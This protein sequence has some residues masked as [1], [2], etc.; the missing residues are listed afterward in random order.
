MRDA[1]GATYAILLGLDFPDERATT[2]E[3]TRHN[4]SLWTL[5]D[6]IAV[7]ECQLHRPVKWTDLRQLLAPGR[8]ADSV[9]AFRSEHLHGRNTLARLALQYAMEEGLAYQKSLA[10]EDG[11]VADAL[12]TAE[13]LT[14]LVNQRMAREGMLGRCSNDDIRSALALA[15]SDLLGL[16]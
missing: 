2:D 13:A 1:V 9:A 15:T 14:L 10:T 8:A 7:L 3:L 6:L 4:V 11:Q 16:A 5:A 12:V